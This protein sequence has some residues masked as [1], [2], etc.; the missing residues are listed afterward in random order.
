MLRGSFRHDSSAFSE[1]GL[2]SAAIYPGKIGPDAVDAL[3]DTTTRWVMIRDEHTGSS[4]KAD[5][6]TKSFKYAGNELNGEE[7]ADWVCLEPAINCLNYQP[8][9]IANKLKYPG[10][11]GLARPGKRSIYAQNADLVFEQ[12]II[13]SYFEN[14]ESS[15]SLRLSKDSESWIDWGTPDASE[16]IGTPGEIAMLDDYF[17]SMPMRG[18][19]FDGKE[20]FRFAPHPE[21]K[22]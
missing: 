16:Q 4:V 3:I 22:F 6:G 1:S 14:E 21:A 11:L 8:Y 20:Y 15:F 2:Y 12:S 13:T 5:Y 10:V 17:W 18:M 19:S 9:L 7:V